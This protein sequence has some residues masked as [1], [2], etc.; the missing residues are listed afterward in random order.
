MARTAL[1]GCLS[2]LGAR[3]LRRLAATRGAEGLLA[4][5]LAPPPLSVITSEHENAYRQD[6]LRGGV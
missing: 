3:L 6:L 1:T 4:L 5:A 2:F